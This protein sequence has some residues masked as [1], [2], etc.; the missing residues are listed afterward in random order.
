MRT[1]ALLALL[2]LPACVDAHVVPLPV[3][4]DAG[5][6]TAPDD[7]G[8]SPDL[9][10][11]TPDATGDQTPPDQDAGQ[12]A[13]SPVDTSIDTQPDTGPDSVDA[14]PEAPTDAGPPAATPSS[15]GQL[16]VTEI[17]ADSRAAIAPAGE[18]PDDVGEWVELLNP[19]DAP[20]DLFGCTILDSSHSETVSQHVVIQP[21]SY[22]VL[23]RSAP[24]F[25][26]DYVYSTLKFSD[27]G[28]EFALACGLATIDLV[29]F[30]TGFPLTQGASLTLDS[31]HLDATQNDSAASWCRGKTVYNTTARGVDLGTPGR[32][33]D[34]CP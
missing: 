27:S 5:Q 21:R 24:G 23:S 14:T 8:A 18:T 3:M 6:E 4:N 7:T 32:P 13:M 16:V 11:P 28:D 25:A 19:G 9:G 2:L 34:S 30:T 29:D 10:A 33:N 20:L 1:P 12:D 31:T 26:P 22:S 15:P 17:M